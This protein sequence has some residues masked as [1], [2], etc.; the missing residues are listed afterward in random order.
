MTQTQAHTDRW[1]RYWDKKARGY[2]REMR[3]FER[4]LFEDSRVWACSQAGGDVLEVAVGTGL[5][6]HAY[7]PG[8]RLTGID[9]SEQMLDIARNRAHELG[10]DVDLRQGDAHSLPFGDATYDAVVCTFGLCAIPDIDAALDEMS[11]VLKPG[12]RLILVDHVESSSRIARVV[13]RA[14]EVVTV[15]MASE[16]FLRRPLSK[17]RERPFEIE[18]SDRFKL[19]VVERL[20]AQKR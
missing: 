18:R 4:V 20:V 5:N 6:L 3:F 1:L 12:G 2:D 9:L 14:A 15:P 7:P 8:V 16:H 17:L 13:Q 19:G 11:R 10:L